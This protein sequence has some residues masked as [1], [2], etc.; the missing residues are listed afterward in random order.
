MTLLVLYATLAILFSFLCSIWEA[1]LLSMPDSYVEVQINQGNPAGPVLRELKKDI[2]R[3]LSAILSLNTIAH[4]VGAILVGKQAETYYGTGGL[5]VAGI[6]I[7]AT[8]IVATLMT[9]GVLI[10]SEIIPKTI[11]ANNWKSLAG[12]TASSLRIITVAMH[13]LVVLSQFV[14]KKLK[15]KGHGGSIS[16]E[17]IS[18]L[19]Q[20]GTREG[21]FLAGESKII[22]N[23]MKFHTLETYSIMTPRT[24]VKAAKQELTVQQ[25]YDQNTQL[26]FSRIPIFDGSKD[27]IT[28]YVLKDVILDCLVKNNGSEL[29]KN[30]SRPI[31]VVKE[32]QTIQDVFNHFLNSREQI[33]LVVDDFGGMAGIV[34]FE[35][36]IETLLGLEIVDELDSTEDMQT[37]ARQNWEKR[38]KAMGILPEEGGAL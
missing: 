13:P 6:E 5:M 16:R 9:L 8:G 11:G 2:D 36:V 7:P 37:L 17:E 22:G 25:F 24:V 29:L 31:T 20:M 38:A 33:A 35:D 28:G 4:T 18:A 26:P 1:V 3:P 10:L 12:F 27:H 34:T 14:T 15:G 23:L 21:V 30:I 32:E 19:A